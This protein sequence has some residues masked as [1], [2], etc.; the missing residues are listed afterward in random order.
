MLLIETN[1]EFLKIINMWNIIVFGQNEYTNS[2]L[3]LSVFTRVC[4]FSFMRVCNFFKLNNMALYEYFWHETLFIRLR[5]FTSSRSTIK[6]NI[7][8]LCIWWIKINISQTI[9]RCKRQNK[10]K[11]YS[12]DSCTVLFY[13]LHILK[14]INSIFPNLLRCL[15]IIFL[16]KFRTIIIITPVFFYKITAVL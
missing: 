16:T 13:T 8:L 2:F 10:S 6:N 3:I 9:Y 7:Y 11:E 4:D 5:L 14:V 12:I 15:L 1:K